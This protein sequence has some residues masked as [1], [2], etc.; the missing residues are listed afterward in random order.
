MILDTGAPV[1]IVILNNEFLGMVRQWQQLFHERRYAETAL[2][3]PDFLGIASAWGIP[4]RRVHTRGELAG[5]IHDLLASPTSF[6]L[7]VRVEREANIFPM[8]PAGASVAQML[9]EAPE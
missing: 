5:A 3:N 8:V 9:L 4:S 2:R 1:K 7:D 6:L